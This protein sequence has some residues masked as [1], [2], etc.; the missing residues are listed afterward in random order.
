MG[1]QEQGEQ[2]AHGQN[3]ARE[4]IARGEG[5]LAEEWAVCAAT[6]VLL[7]EAHET[8]TRR[9]V[10]RDTHTSE[11]EEGERRKAREGA[12]GSQPA[13]GGRE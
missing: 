3:D 11:R 5:V 9:Y 4:T 10:E 12:R 7:S 2:A 1:E 6:T 8:H 13:R